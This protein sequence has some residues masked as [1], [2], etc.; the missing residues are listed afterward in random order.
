MLGSYGTMHY[1]EFATI[2][3]SIYQFSLLF[4]MQVNKQHEV[5]AELTKLKSTF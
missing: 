5:T 1:F 2:V 4:A 3:L